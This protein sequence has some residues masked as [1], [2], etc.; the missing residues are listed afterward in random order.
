VAH[1]DVYGGTGERVNG[2]APEPSGS[3]DMSAPRP[4]DPERIL[5]RLDLGTHLD[6][7]SLKQRF[8][9]TMFEV[10]A[11]RY[12]RFTRV[13]S[14]GMDRGWKRSLVREIPPTDA[15]L[16]IVDLACGTGDF[17]FMA[18]RAS[19]AARVVGFDVARRMIRRATEARPAENA[20]RVRFAVADMT[21]LPVSDDFADVVTVG[22]GVRNAPT[23]GAAI[24]EIWRILRPG[25]TLLVLDFYRPPNPVWRRLFL[26]YLRAAGSA[27][28][29]AWH[30]IPVAY[31]YIAPSVERHLTGAGFSRALEDAG[32][33]VTRERRR[34]FGGICLHT[35]RRL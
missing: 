5:P 8:V 25:G 12:D 2:A 10:I 30:R 19:A 29:W 33:R 16:R 35:A 20:A 14:F 32:F 6:D 23:P 3:R 9:T 17:A 13:F 28:G 11:P 26:W 24:D 27:V 31:G 4:T 21:R 1:P 22:Y 34:L 7:P 18:A 15:G